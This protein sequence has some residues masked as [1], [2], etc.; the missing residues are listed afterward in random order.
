[1]V[2]HAID[3]LG[4]SDSTK[5][6]L[7]VWLGNN[8]T[9][10]DRQIAQFW[11]ILDQHKADPFAGVIVGNEVLYRKD[12]TSDE[13]AKILADVKKNLTDHNWDLPLAT[14]DLGDNWTEDLASEVDVVMANIHPF[15][16]GVEAQQAASWTW[17][18]WQNHDVA[19]T[20][21]LQGKT[22]VIS[23]TGWPSGG[24]NDCG[25]S[26]CTSDT[27]GSVAGINEMNIFLDD[28][29]CQALKNGTEY[30]W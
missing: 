11:Q 27:Q 26:T 22:H 7:G 12:L 4:I 5:V 29:V 10:N 19:V 6:W 25:E 28:W 8:D 24:G 21:N 1:M 2:L 18:F 14:S 16:A 9:T 15:F 30:F 13:L 3:R 23:E 17:S 20:K